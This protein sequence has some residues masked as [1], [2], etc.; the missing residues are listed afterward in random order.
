MGFLYNKKPVSVKTSMVWSI[1]FIVFITHIMLFSVASIIQHAKMHREYISLAESAM[2]RLNGQFN[3]HVQLISRTA[4]SLGARTDFGSLLENKD[5]YELLR[6]LD[7]AL[8]RQNFQFRLFQDGGSEISNTFVS[9]PV[10]K[11]EFTQ[12]RLSNAFDGEISLTF[13]YSEKSLFLIVLVPLRNEQFQ[14]RGVLVLIEEIDHKILNEMKTNVNAEIA[15]VAENMV[16]VTNVPATC[17]NEWIH[18]VPPSATF[19]NSGKSSLQEGGVVTL[20][21]R[22]YY[23]TTGPFYDINREIIAT[24]TVFISVSKQIERYD[25]SLLILIFFSLMSLLIMF[26]VSTWFAKRLV[27]PIL[28]L[29]QAIESF[30]RDSFKLIDVHAHEREIIELTQTFNRMQIELKASLRQAVLNENLA[31]LGRFSADVLHDIKNPLEGLKLLIGGLERKVSPESPE[32]LYAEEIRYAIL[33]LEKLILETLD[34]ARITTPE[35]E[36]IQVCSLVHELQ[37]ELHHIKSLHFEDCD[38]TDMI[39]CDSRQMKRIL[40]NVIANG[41]D[42]VGETGNVTVRITDSDCHVSIIIED[43]GPGIDEK[44]I[45]SIYEPF[46]TTKKKG[47]G[48]GLSI[49]YQ[50]ININGF[51][52]N[53]EKRN[54]RGTRFIIT[55][56]KAEEE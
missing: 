15:L 20:Q 43:D 16:S 17:Q 53:F 19:K 49:A 50:L 11:L 2:T 48:L 13:E 9:S 24:Q 6:R 45:N 30:D 32:A 3:H 21:K 34:F 12:K 52:I 26:F 41:L 14:V 33:N 25:Q 38:L 29:T 28:K 42:A 1:V 37:H 35:K 23:M 22:P 46:F 54:P 40:S 36:K 44:I 47:H 39:L 31:I 56:P 8:K 51:T 18:C 55:A 7:W 4:R 10:R 5:P 27:N